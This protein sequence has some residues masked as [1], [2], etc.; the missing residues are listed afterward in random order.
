MDFPICLLIKRYHFLR[1]KRTLWQ[2]ISDNIIVVEFHYDIVH[3]F[4]SRNAPAAQRE[5]VS[6]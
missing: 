1:T 5:I 3:F 4:F 2:C 6:S